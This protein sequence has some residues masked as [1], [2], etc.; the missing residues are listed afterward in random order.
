MAL[1]DQVEALATKIEMRQIRLYEADRYYEGTQP[2]AFLSPQA[3]KALGNRLAAIS[4]NYVRLATDSLAE[5]LTVDGFKIGS[6]SLESVWADWQRCGMERGSKIAI[7]EALVLGQSFVTVWAGSNGDPAITVESPREMA[8]TRHPITHEITSALKRWRDDQGVA[9]AVLFQADRIT[10]WKGPEVPE[11]GS[12]PTT[13]WHYSD[14]YP[15]PLGVVPVVDLTNSGR[16]FDFDG[17]PEAKGIWGL[18]DAL[19][20]LL[21]DVMVGSESTALPRRWAT[22]L[23]VIEDAE[24][25]PVNPFSQEPGSVWQSEDPETRFGGFPEPKLEAYDT[26]IS[27][28]IRQIGAISGLPDHLIGVKDT[29]PSSAEQ[30]RAAESSLVARAYSHHTIFGPAFARVAALAEAIR[31][32]GRVRSD[33]RTVWKSPESR[34]RAQEADA[35]AK[36]VAEIG[37]AHV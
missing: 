31:S 16:L 35:A 19:A 10:L 36:L 28:L 37:R 7:L 18:V 27:M 34:T 8:I 20:K 29:D 25:N 5:R 22:G 30:I 17:T 24:G 6:E 11:G 13:G 23:Q 14:T 3:K 15:N 33:L 2:L 32:G 21:A 1:L 9:R 4:A 12:L 26:L